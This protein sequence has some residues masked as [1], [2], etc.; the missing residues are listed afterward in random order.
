MMMYGKQVIG[1][2][3]PT[4][5]DISKTWS[6]ETLKAK[7]APEYFEDNKESYIEMLKKASIL[8]RFGGCKNLSTGEF[9]NLEQ[10]KN[11]VAIVGK[12]KYENGT[13]FIESLILVK[14]KK[15]KILMLIIR[16]IKT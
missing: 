1:A 5:R 15:A 9:K 3:G 7:I 14:D 6:I 16:P 4:L 8:G 10:P 13:A 11:S 12:C 2:I